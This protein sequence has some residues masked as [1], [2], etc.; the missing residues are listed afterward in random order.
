MRKSYCCMKS[1][2]IPHIDRS[3]Y[4]KPEL[5]EIISPTG[6]KKLMEI[7]AEQRYSNKNLLKT[8]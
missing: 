6:M 8:Y 5:M 4:I 7:S 3:K 1:L 2:T